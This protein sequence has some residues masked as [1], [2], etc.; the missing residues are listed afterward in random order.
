M[1]IYFIQ[2]VVDTGT[3]VK[4]SPHK[5]LNGFRSVTPSCADGSDHWLVYKVVDGEFKFLYTTPNEPCGDDADPE[6]MHLVQEYG[7]LSVYKIP[8]YIFSSS[9]TRP[10]KIR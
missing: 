6:V 4:D 5:M 8:L 10:T 3:I 9:T 2:G 7:D 1:D